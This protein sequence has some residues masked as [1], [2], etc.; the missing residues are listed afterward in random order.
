VSLIHPHNMNTSGPPLEEGSPV[1]DRMIEPA[2]VASL[3]AWI[4]GAPERVSV[5][6]VTIWPRAAGIASF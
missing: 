5:G 4:A 2:D 6:N 1:R 3:V